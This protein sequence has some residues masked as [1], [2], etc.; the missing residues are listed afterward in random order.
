M[1][2]P[3]FQEECLKEKCTAYEL[4]Q[5]SSPEDF[6]DGTY[7]Y[8]TIVQRDVHYCNALKCELPE[9]KE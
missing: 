9:R 5:E 3:F 7:R 8:V 1:I 2:C 4:K 6:Q